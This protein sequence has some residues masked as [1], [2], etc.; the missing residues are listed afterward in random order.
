MRRPVHLPRQRRLQHL[1]H[2]A[3]DWREGRYADRG[4]PRVQWRRAE[5]GGAGVASGDVRDHGESET[6]MLNVI[7]RGS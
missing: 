4:G 3:A 1:Q 2:G 6:V 7:A 5:D